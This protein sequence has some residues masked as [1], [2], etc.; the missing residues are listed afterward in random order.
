M[1][2]SFRW[3]SS[4][5]SD[6]NYDFHVSFKPEEQSTAEYNYVNKGFPSSEGPGASVFYRDGDQVFH[7]Y[8]TYARGLDHLIASY[9][10]LDLTPMGRNE[11]GLSH[12]MSWVRHHDRYET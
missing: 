11:A 8:S 1:G 7:T 12:G 3:L 9:Q 6:F 4:A 2:W 5:G 10:Y